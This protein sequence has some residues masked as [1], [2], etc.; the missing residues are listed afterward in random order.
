MFNWGKTPEYEAKLQDIRNKYK[1][2]CKYCGW[3]NV[4]YPFE[5]TDKKVCKNC[6]HYVYTNKRSE[7]KDKMKGLM[8]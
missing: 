1:Y 3:D 7:F 6:G 8:K 2:R 4:I 5:K